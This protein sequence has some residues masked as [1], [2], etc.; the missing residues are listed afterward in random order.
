MQDINNKNENYFKCGVIC[1]SVCRPTALGRTVKIFLSN[2]IIRI[3]SLLDLVP[4]LPPHRKNPDPGCPSHGKDPGSAH[5][6]SY[7]RH[8]PSYSAAASTALLLL[9]ILLMHNPRN[10]E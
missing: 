8:P 9:V 7:C 3:I 5:G 6:L 4:P 10:Q 2:L 1:I